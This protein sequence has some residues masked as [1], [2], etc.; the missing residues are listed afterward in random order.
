MSEQPSPQV[1]ADRERIKAITSL[2]EATGQ[3]KAALAVALVGATVDEAK[4]VLNITASAMTAD[5][6]AASINRRNGR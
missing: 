2:P 3:L 4:V 6:V 1:A 5:E